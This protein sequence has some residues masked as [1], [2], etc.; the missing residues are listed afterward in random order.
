MSATVLTPQQLAERWQTDV[1]SIYALITK[2]EIP[3]VGPL[4]KG[5]R[6]SVYRIPIGYVESIEQGRVARGG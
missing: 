6:R 2:G 1:K 5:L 3:T 4:A